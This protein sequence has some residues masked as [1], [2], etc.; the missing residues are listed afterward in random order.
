TL[1][2]P[3]RAHARD[4]PTALKAMGVPRYVTGNYLQR[5]RDEGVL[6]EPS[7]SAD[8]ESYTSQWPTLHQAA[9][10]ASAPEECPAGMHTLLAVL[11]GE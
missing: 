3:G 6:L 2:G 5:F 1:E 4:C 8:I 9:A 11:E 7:A 10:D